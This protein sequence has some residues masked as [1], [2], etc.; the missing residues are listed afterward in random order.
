MDELP[1][2]AQDVQNNVANVMAIPNY[3]YAPPHL[4]PFGYGLDEATQAAVKELAHVQQSV[5]VLQQ[6][7]AIRADEKLMAAITKYLRG[8]KAKINHMLVGLER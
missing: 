8:E 7:A 1:E 3:P 2:C 4:A 6:A 5:M